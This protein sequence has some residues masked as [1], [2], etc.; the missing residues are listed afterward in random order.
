M[1]SK[2]MKYII[3]S[4]GTTEYPVIFHEKLAHINVAEGII[5]ESS[6]SSWSKIL[7]RLSA[8]SAGFVEMPEIEVNPFS[9]SESLKLKPRPQ[10]Q[11]VLRNEPVD[12]ELLKPVE[13]SAPKKSLLEKA[14]GAKAR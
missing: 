5:G 3:L 4:D 11:A 12:P 10:D 9:G 14:W 6:Y 13:P 1:V 2:Q 7:G 8:V